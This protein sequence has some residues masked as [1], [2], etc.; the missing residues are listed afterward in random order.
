ML[1]WK[2]K[3]SHDFKLFADY[4]Q[5][6]LQD[7]KAKGD[8]SGSW[9]EQAVADLLAVA[10]GT[11]GV[12]TVRNMTVPVK[13]VVQESAAEENFE[14]WDHVVDCSID[15]PSGMIVIAGCTDYFPDAA[16]IK[17]KPGHYH[18]RICYGGLDTLSEDGFEGE[19]CY[20]VFLWPGKHTGVS[21]RKKW[22]AKK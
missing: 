21:V 16:R 4:F 1:F 14:I 22:Q 12:G 6:Y 20:Q 18:A 19:D 9:T 3:N 2:K 15:I 8:L 7:E 17:V 11:I 10:P 13:V 5:F